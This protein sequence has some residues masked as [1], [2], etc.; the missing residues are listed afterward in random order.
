MSMK[1][2]LLLFNI[3]YIYQCHCLNLTIG[4]LLTYTESKWKGFAEGNILFF[5]YLPLKFFATRALGNWVATKKNDVFF[6]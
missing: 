3:L 2:I 4:V 6:W 1:I 5:V